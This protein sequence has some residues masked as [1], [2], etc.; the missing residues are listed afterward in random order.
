MNRNIPLISIIAINSKLHL[1]KIYY[2]E[3]I[4]TIFNV[5]IKSLIDLYYLKS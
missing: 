1:T 4:R 3:T 2:S 5:R